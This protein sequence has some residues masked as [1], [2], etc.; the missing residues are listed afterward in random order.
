MTKKQVGL[1]SALLVMLISCFVMVK[2]Q[3]FGT[4]AHEPV[5]T[6]SWNLDGTM[7]AVGM[8]QGWLHIFDRN[9]VEITRWKADAVAIASVSWSP[10]GKYL[11]TSGDEESIRLW[12]VETWSLAQELG[13]FASGGAYSLAWNTDGSLLLGSGFDTFQ[14]WDLNS[15]KS[16]T[17]PLSVTLFDIGWRP[18]SDRDFSLISG[19]FVA[20]YTIGDELE[21]KYSFES[22]ELPLSRFTLDWSLDGNDLIVAGKE[23]SIRVWDGGS[24]ELLA[25]IP[26]R[27]HFVRDI[28]FI[29]DTQAVGVTQGGAVVL[30]DT[31]ANS[32]TTIV[33]FDASLLTMAWNPFTYQL[34]VGG[35][36]GTVINT[37]SGEVRQ[38]DGFLDFIELGEY[39]TRPETS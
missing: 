20:L 30:V 14:A 11:A 2:A 33:Q 15:G 29:S 35:Y 39:V 12:E 4:L 16:L 36:T 1:V 34:S 31:K 28:A 22:I 26:A 21:G 9:H 27:E 37:V 13:H 32:V 10:D 5:R 23:N 24:G 25:E 38:V 17:D 6:M 19:S 8:P 3:D 18:H 7:I